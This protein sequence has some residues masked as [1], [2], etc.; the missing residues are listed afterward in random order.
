MLARSIHR[1]WTFLVFLGLAAAWAMPGTCLG[2]ILEFRNGYEGTKPSDTYSAPSLWMIANSDDKA[3][4]NKTTAEFAYNNQKARRLLLRWDLRS[5]APGT[6][7][8]RASFVLHLHSHNEM[9]PPGTEHGPGSV[10]VRALAGDN[11]AWMEDLTKVTGNH[12]N[13]AD[14]VPWRRAGGEE[15]HIGNAHSV[16]MGEA[17]WPGSM[18]TWT[19]TLDRQDPDTAGWLAIVQGW[20]DDPATNLGAVFHE[21]KTVIPYAVH[22]SGGQMDLRPTLVIELPEPACVFTVAGG[23]AVVLGRGGRGMR[24]RA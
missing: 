13:T 16:R 14:G 5:I 18:W 4:V 19:L 20:I 7:I 3:R 6:V 10:S 23:L 24:R 11:A 2:G 21:T 12:Q 8:D 22:A 9:H 15:T 1:R 17:D